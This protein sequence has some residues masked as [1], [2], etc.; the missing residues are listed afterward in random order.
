MNEIHCR[1]PDV[2]SYERKRKSDEQCQLYSF[3]YLFYLYNILQ[4][5][6]YIFFLYVYL[7]NDKVTELSCEKLWVRNSQSRKIIRNIHMKLMF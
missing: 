4:D 1:C 2:E 7:K 3:I 5:R 6:Y